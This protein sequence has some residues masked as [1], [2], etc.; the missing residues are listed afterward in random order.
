MRQSQ[1]GGTPLPKKIPAQNTEYLRLCKAEAALLQRR[2]KKNAPLLSQLLSGRVPDKLQ[3][4]L[5]SAF[6]HA[7]ES[8]FSH[9]STVIDKTVS[10]DERG[11]TYEIRRYSAQLRPDRRNLRAFS[12]DAGSAQTKN[13]LL[14]GTFGVG[15]GLLGIGLPDIPVF[16][17]LLLK[18]VYETALSF[19]FDYK[20]PGEQYFILLLLQSALSAGEDAVHLERTVDAWIAAHRK[21]PAGV[22][23]DAEF[24]RQM[25]ASA[26]ALA[27]ALLYMKF[28]Q[29]IPIVG[30]VGGISDVVCMQQISEYTRLKY[31][32]RRLETGFTANK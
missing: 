30:A 4:T 14:S 16:A 13:L 24:R 8:V 17:A 23:T 22:P 2:Q 29:G 26:D 10:A 21:I 27:D 9:G 32:R 5:R 28:V 6:F 20:T 15:L 31:Q 1:T 3:Q 7:F 19:G 11:K 25:R 18:N 12:R